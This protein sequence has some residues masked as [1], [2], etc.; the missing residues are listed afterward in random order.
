MDQ[1][2]DNHD[3]LHQLQLSSP[4]YADSRYSFIVQRRAEGMEPAPD[5]A[6]FEQAYEKQRLGTP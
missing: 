2:S 6:A 5:D 3:D 4:L 1:Q